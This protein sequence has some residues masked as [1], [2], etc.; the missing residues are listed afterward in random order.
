MFQ[1]KGINLKNKT[2]VHSIR[3]FIRYSSI[4][5]TTWLLKRFRVSIGILDAQKRTTINFHYILVRNATN[6]KGRGGGEGGEVNMLHI[7][8]NNSTL[9]NSIN[10]DIALTVSEHTFQESRRH[11]AWCKEWLHLQGILQQGLQLALLRVWW[12]L[13]TNLLSAWANTIIR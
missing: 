1:T 12:S 10:V 3:P 5:H 7:H 4:D 2:F 9:N 6:H 8:I 11:R 13:K